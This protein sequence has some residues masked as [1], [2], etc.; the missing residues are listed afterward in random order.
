MGSRYDAPFAYSDTEIIVSLH[1]PSAADNTTGRVM[2]ES[3]TT[4]PLTR[5]G[6]VQFAIFF[7]V[8]FS[9][10]LI[11]TAEWPA[12]LRQIDV[13]SSERYL[14]PQ[15]PDPLS[16]VRITGRRRALIVRDQRNPIAR[17]LRV[18]FP[19]KIGI[20]YTQHPDPQFQLKG[21]TADA[22]GMT[23][24]LLCNALLPHSTS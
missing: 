20:N 7:R 13:L 18:S 23:S 12:A 14:R 1:Q 4:S 11:T 10:P 6:L 21:C 5:T 3:P 16:F 9:R 24:F 2:V 8:E 19:L 15:M 17:G 22:Y